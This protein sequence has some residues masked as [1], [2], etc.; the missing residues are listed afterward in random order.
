LEQPTTYEVEVEALR[1]NETAL[2]SF[3]V[4]IATILRGL[5]RS[6]VLVK[7]TTKQQ[8]LEMLASLTGGVR[9]D[10][11]FVFPGPQPKTLE[12]DNMS[13][14]MLADIPNIRDPDLDYNVTDK[15]DG[16]RTMGYVNEVGRLYLIDQSLNIYETGLQVHG[17]AKSLV[18]G[19]WITK[20]NSNNSQIWRIG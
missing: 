17:C 7:Q 14:D 6:F 10:D 1:G 9:R 3:F 15:A 20:R 2:K 11:K 13:P 8:V 4:G 12:R 5:Q 18:D 16:L 19:E